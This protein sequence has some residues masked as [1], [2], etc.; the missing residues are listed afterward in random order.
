MAAVH[1]RPAAQADLLEI[2]TYIAEDS[3]AHADAFIDKLHKSIQ[4]L[5]RR[6]GLGR[7]R[8]ELFPGIRSLP[9]G[10]YVIFYREVA[11]GLEI[12]R[13]LHG[14]RDFGSLFRPEE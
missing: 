7:R 11:K 3:L 10:N 8:D 4:L 9:V 1:I 6:P 5:R 2:W 14:A 13:V 12:V